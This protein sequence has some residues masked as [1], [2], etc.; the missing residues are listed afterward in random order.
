MTTL[1]PH[2]I[3]DSDLNALCQL[4]LASSPD[5]NVQLYD[6]IIFADE[7]WQFDSDGLTGISGVPVAGATQQFLNNRFA[8]DGLPEGLANDHQ[9]VHD[10]YHGTIDTNATAVAGD[11][12]LRPTWY[13]PNDIGFRFALI[14]KAQSLRKQIQTSYTDSGLKWNGA[15]RSSAYTRAGQLW[16]NVELENANN[17]WAAQSG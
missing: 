11:P 2:P 17:I 7:Y 9:E 15:T 3:T 10:W 12:I 13:V 4:H 14:A 16:P 1:D 5:P 8:A 6:N